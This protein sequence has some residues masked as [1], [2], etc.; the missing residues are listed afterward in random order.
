MTNIFTKRGQDAKESMNAG[1]VDLK[2][3][4]IRLKEDESVRVRVLGT[5]DYVEYQAVGDFNL[6]VYTQPSLLPLGKPDA[7]DEAK[8]IA[9]NLAGDDEDHELFPFT[10]LYPKK[11]YVFAFA[12]LDTGEIRVWDCSKNQAKG[13]IKQIE[14]YEEDLHEVAFNFKRTGSGRETVYSLNPILRLKGDDQEKFDKFEGEKVT[15]EIFNAVLVPRT[16]EQ[17]VETLKQAGFP[18]HDYFEVTESEDEGQ[19]EDKD[20]TGGF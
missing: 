16:Y 8:Q 11:R 7:L 6:G 1:Q 15:D 12:D 14:E 9:E 17:Q 3:I 5:F 19:D 18:V 10:R 2:K 4:Y 13:I 20:P